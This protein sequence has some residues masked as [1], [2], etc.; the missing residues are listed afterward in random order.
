M[1][2]LVTFYS[3]T[4]NTKKIGEEIAKNLKADSDNIIDKKNRKGIFSYFIAGK[5][6]LFKKLTKIENKKDP[7]KYNLVI[8]GTPIWVGSIAPAIRTYLSKNRFNKVAF[9]CT[10][11]SKQTRAFKEMEKLSKKPLAVLELR[12]KTIKNSKEKIR[13]FCGNL[14]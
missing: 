14:K 5:D 7:S 3:R 11:G 12:T 2:T 10:C 1:K 8:I 13:E 4:N 6:A 9:F